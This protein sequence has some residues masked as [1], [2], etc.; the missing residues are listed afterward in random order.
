L[1]IATLLSYIL[2]STLHLMKTLL[3]LLLTSFAF[4][5]DC[6]YTNLSKEFDIKVTTTWYGSDAHTLSDSLDVT[7][8]I[9]NKKT[10]ASQQIH[11]GSSWMLEDAYTNCNSVRSYTTGFNKTDEILDDD[12]GDMVV[13]DLNFD[14]RDDIAFKQ[15]AGGNGGPYYNFYFQD[16]TGKFVI[17]DFLSTSM[18]YFPYK[19]IAEEKT[20]VAKVRLN[21]Y[22]S[23][24]E[25][26]KYIAPPAGNGWRK[27]E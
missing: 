4:A 7:V 18:A 13:A 20:L 3:F 9:I 21:T 6:S 19:I 12:F 15:N 24:D 2:Q 16:K 25:Y 8:D 14:G 26:Y 22:E 27:I 5:Q 1:N 17:N 10:K 23:K 11:F